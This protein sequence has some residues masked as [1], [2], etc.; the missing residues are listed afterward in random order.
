[1]SRFR[2]ALALLLMALAAFAASPSAHAT[3]SLPTHIA[4]TVPV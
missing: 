4:Q 2:N 1:M 3:P